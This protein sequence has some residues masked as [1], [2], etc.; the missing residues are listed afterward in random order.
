MSQ[1]E[2]Q[3][4]L[5]SANEISAQLERRSLR[6]AGFS[7]TRV[8]YNGIEA[9]RL[10][11]QFDK[12]EDDFQP[13][14]I[15]CTQKLADMEGEQFCAIVRQH[16]D[17]LDFPI[18][19]ITSNESEKEQLQKL[20]SEASDLLGRPYT[21]DNLKKHIY[22]LLKTSVTSP[23]VIDP[24]TDTSAFQAAL[25][26]YGILLRPARQPEDYLKVGMKCL[27][28]NQWTQ[29]MSAFKMA[30]E[31]LRIKAEAELGM[32]A[33]YRG[34]G[35]L[36]RFQDWLARGAETLVTGKRWQFARTTYARLLQHD[37]EARNPFLAQA[38][39]LMRQRQYDEAAFT[40]VQGIT[41]MRGAKAGEHLAKICFAAPEPEAMSLALKKSLAK[42]G[43]QKANDLIQEIHQSLAGL[44]RERVQRQRE[45]AAERKWQLSRKIAEQEKAHQLSKS[46]RVEVRPPEEDN[47]QVP[48]LDDFPSEHEKLD[49][50][51]DEA[52][53]PLLA[54]LQI[55]D[56]TSGILTEKPKLNELLSVMKFT[57]K[58]SRKQ[59]E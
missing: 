40:L 52:E 17:L 24:N 34:K 33:A 32:A 46:E 6:E 23:I 53:T 35:D 51:A 5:L 45:Q 9:A 2:K 27:Q 47:P 56:A 30:L 8:L 49:E 58:L 43:G 13:D 14:L 37:P 48:L 39:Q 29:A 4:L 16:P 31:D 10:L 38:H 18:L 1:S 15:I 36:K 59:K 26:S 44:A 41:L 54:P 3:I 25:D 19:L 55:Q 22:E 12:S 57:W 50:D 20:G 11:A 42:M 28:E 7:R 21:I